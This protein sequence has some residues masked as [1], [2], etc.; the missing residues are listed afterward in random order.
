M[1]EKK[2]KDL[3]VDEF[4]RY[5]GVTS[6]TVLRWIKYGEIEAIK[7]AGKK[8]YRIGISNLSKAKFEKKGINYSHLKFKK[9]EQAKVLI[10]DDDESIV[11]FIN[12]VFTRNGFQTLTSTNAYEAM[13]L[14]REELPLILT[15]DLTMPDSNG[16]D[17][18]KMI[19]D[20]GVKDKIW[21]IVIS[22]MGEEELHSA[23]D[24][25]GDFYLHK[26]IHQNDLDKII[27][28]LTIDLK[29]NAA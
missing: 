4:A 23:I 12:P 29:S 15:L 10:V 11:D 28:K 3:S 14:L 7:P 18:L 8:D 13:I 26:P 16:F 17:V 21:I 20:L 25:G 9:G 1:K 6:K 24:L 27:K 22:A 5:C 2:A 19:N